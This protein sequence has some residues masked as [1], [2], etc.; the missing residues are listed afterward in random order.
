MEIKIA[1][2]YPELLNLYGDRGNIDVLTKRCKWRKIKV[3]LNKVNLGKRFSGRSDIYVIGGGQDEDEYKV[4]KD[5]IKHRYQINKLVEDGKVFLCLCA[6]LQLFGK[7]FID[8]LGRKIEGLGILDIETK[9][10]S[11]N[12]RDRS[13]GNIVIEM[14]N[15]VFDMRKMQKTTLVGFENHIG[16]TFLGSKVMPLGEVI[17]GRGNNTIDNTEGAVYKNVF[18]SYLHGPLLPKNPHFADYLISL[19]LKRKYRNFKKLKKLDDNDE[20]YAHEYILDQVK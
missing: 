12:V 1:H 16:Q 7:Y 10:P 5:L 6:G 4:Y 18:G 14:N 13:I 2:L 3:I 8:G 11:D 15:K 9:A 20:F 19:A 17:R